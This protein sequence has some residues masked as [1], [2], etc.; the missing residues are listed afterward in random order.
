[1]Q[2]LILQILQGKSKYLA[3]AGTEIYLDRAIRSGRFFNVDNRESR[4]IVTGSLDN[5]SVAVCYDS[6][7]G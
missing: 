2:S 1:M 7:S 3:Q 5:R 6:V 4:T